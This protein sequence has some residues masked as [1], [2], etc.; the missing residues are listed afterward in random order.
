MLRHN[1]GLSGS[2]VD[3]EGKLGLGVSEGDCRRYVKMC[4]SKVYHEDMQ[5]FNKTYD[6]Y[7][8]IEKAQKYPP[9]GHENLF[10]SSK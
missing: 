8:R 3:C 1:M 2:G 4:K 9:L 7:C 5:L 6:Y 10:S